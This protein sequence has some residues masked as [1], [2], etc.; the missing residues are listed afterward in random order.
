MLSEE[1]KQ[2]FNERKIE[3][4]EVRQFYPTLDLQ[5]GEDRAP[6]LP[7]VTEEKNGNS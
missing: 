7:I 4:K 2:T 1:A 6:G 5:N 3:V